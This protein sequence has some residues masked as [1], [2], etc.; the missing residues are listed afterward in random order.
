MMKDASDGMMD[1]MMG[2]TQISMGGGMMGGG[3]MQ[4]NAGTSGLAMAMTDYMSSDMNHSGLTA[5]DMNSLIAQLSLSNG[6]L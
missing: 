6:Q 4:S 1:G 2:N 5:A 3:M